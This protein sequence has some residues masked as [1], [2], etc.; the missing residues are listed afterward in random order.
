GMLPRL[1]SGRASPRVW[2]SIVMKR[3]SARACSPVIAR[4]TPYSERSSAA[5][6]DAEPTEIS[7]AIMAQNTR[8]PRMCGSFHSIQCRYLEISRT[9]A[10]EKVGSEPDGGLETRPGSLPAR[11]FAR[12]KLRILLRRVNSSFE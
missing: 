11:R 5:H 1:F 4:V 7:S 8:L 12:R 2:D 3:V 10:F 9:A 6:T